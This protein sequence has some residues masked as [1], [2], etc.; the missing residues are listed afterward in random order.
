MS[1]L[2]D[3]SNGSLS[4][5]GITRLPRHSSME[6]LHVVY[7]EQKKTTYPNSRLT[8]E[9][10]L[11]EGCIKATSCRRIISQLS[12]SSYWRPCKIYRKRGRR[13]LTKEYTFLVGYSIVGVSK[14]IGFLG[15]DS[16]WN[17]WRLETTC[18]CYT[19]H[20]F[21][22]ETGLF[23]NSPKIEGAGRE[24]WHERSRKHKRGR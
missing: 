11:C 12:W 17:Y 16:G 2:T 9:Q 8:N 23:Q 5:W 18:C 21:V 20:S 19:S 6:G 4:A 14:S 22:F 24:F 15:T 3:V 10:L 1:S 7:Y 13:Q